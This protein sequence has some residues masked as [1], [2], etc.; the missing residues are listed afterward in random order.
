MFSQESRRILSLNHR[1]QAATVPIFLRSLASTLSRRFPINAPGDPHPSLAFQPYI[2]SII[3]LLT[4]PSHFSLPPAPLEH[5]DLRSD[6]SRYL[7]ATHV[8]PLQVIQALLPLLRANPA[9]A[10][11]AATNNKGKKNIV[12]CIPAVDARVGLPFAAPQA[13]SAAA[14]LRGV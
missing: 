14:T 9:R 7:N 6:Y 8:T 5:V 10:R 13:M 2:Q 3:S 4:L 11:D 12:V 1:S